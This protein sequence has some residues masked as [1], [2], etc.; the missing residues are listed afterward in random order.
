MSV[1]VADP[2][3]MGGAKHRIY[4]AIHERFAAAGIV[5]ASPTR[6]VTLAGLP[7]K[8]ADMIGDRRIRGDEPEPAPRGPHH[9]ESPA[10][11]TA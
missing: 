8:L 5:L 9:A 4:K 1:F 3:L 2:G 6:E 11:V 10:A 7:E